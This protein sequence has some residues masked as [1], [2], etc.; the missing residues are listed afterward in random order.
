M[1][2]CK[3]YL[4][5][6]SDKLLIEKFNNIYTHRFTTYNG[7]Y[8]GD[9]VPSLNSACSTLAVFTTIIMLLCCFI[10]INY[11]LCICTVGFLHMYSYAYAVLYLLFY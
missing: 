7:L 8:S 10:S 4:K 1:Y 3:Q 6:Y 11:Y 9:I 2:S 5:H